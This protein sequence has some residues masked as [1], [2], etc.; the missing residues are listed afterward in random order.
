MLCTNI[1]Q[2][3]QLMSDST[4]T[5]DTNSARLGSPVPSAFSARVPLTS[6]C[7]VVSQQELVELTD[8]NTFINT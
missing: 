6:L 1:L 7:T 8:I 2:S 3:L 5:L 4:K